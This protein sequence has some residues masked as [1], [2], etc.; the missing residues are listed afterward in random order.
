MSGSGSPY[1]GG[2]ALR[3]IVRPYPRR[4]TGEPISQSFDLGTRVFEFAF[5]HAPQ[6]EAPTE[7]FVPVYQYPQGCRVQVS[8][9]T[10]EFEPADQL[11]R[12]WHTPQRPTHTI[13]ILPG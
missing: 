11:L 2:R 10:F 7:I 12:Y 13:R 8:D 4:T 5:R 1:D 9:G 3:A 6:I